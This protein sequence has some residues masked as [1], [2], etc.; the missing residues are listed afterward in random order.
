[1]RQRV[2]QRNK[3]ETSTSNIAKNYNQFKTFNGK[4]YTGMTGRT[5]TDGC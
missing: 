1:M 3:I 5:K 4:Q 2:L